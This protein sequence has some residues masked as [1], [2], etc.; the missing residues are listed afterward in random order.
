MTLK[1][2]H[3]YGAFVVVRERENR[4]HGEGTQLICNKIEVD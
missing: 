3:G 2:R 4:S 1:I